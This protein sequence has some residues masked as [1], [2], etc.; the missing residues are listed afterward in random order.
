VN[1]GENQLFL[2]PVAKWHVASNI[3]LNAG[4]LIPVSQNVATPE[5]NAIVTAGIA[6]KF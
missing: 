1:S 3:D 4:V 5:A 6:I 2:G